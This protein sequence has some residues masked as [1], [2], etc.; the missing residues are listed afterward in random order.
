MRQE[1]RQIMK[2]NLSDADKFWL[3]RE[4]VHEVAQGMKRGIKPNERIPF[5]VNNGQVVR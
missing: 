2:L 3:I 4:R 5:K 1:I